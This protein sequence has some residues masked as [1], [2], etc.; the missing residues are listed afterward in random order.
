MGLFGLRWERSK[1]KLRICCC[2]SMQESITIIHD[3]SVCTFQARPRDPQRRLQLKA[4]AV[5][6]WTW[7]GQAA[8]GIDGRAWMGA[9]REESRTHTLP[10]PPPLLGPAWG[11]VQPLSLW[12]IVEMSGAAPD[13][14][15]PCQGAPASP[16]MFRRPTLSLQ[17]PHN[18][19]QKQPR[20]ASCRLN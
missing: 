20:E 3:R 1:Y 6:P 8:K 5:L 17:L 4:S 12:V 10:A 15:Q 16:N 13:P 18:I 19:S 9:K 14:V 11:S 2:R 7:P